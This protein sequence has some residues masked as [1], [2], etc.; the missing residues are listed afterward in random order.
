MGKYIV[1][2]YNTTVIDLDT[3][4]GIVLSGNGI[5][6]NAGNLIYSGRI[7]DNYIYNTKTVENAF[8]DNNDYPNSILNGNYFLI[9]DKPYST[10]YYESFAINSNDNSIS[11][12]RTKILVDRITK[13]YWSWVPDNKAYGS[14]SQF[15]YWSNLFFLE[16]NEDFSIKS[17][18]KLIVDDYDSSPYPIAIHN[19]IVYMDNGKCNLLSSPLVLESHGLSIDF[20]YNTENDYYLASQTS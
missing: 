18:I 12:F 17:S 9:V 16:L 6:K 10:S 11:K 20:S 15:T 1:A 8:Y 13:R 2:G 7:G 3:G 14:S 19:N 5:S 4:T